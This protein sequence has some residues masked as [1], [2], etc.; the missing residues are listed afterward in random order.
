MP[1]NTVTA[2]V[3]IAPVVIKTLI[4]HSRKKGHKF[5]EEDETAEATDDILFDESFHIVKAFIELGTRNTVESL[6][7]FTNTHVPAPYWA[8]VVPVQIPLSTCNKAADH[9][10]EWFGP[11]DLK[12]VVGG[13]KWWQVRGLDGVD[14]EWITEKEYL[15]SESTLRGVDTNGTN[16]ELLRM[17]HLESVMLYVHGG[18][19]FWGS[20]NTHR[21]Q[22]IRY[23]QLHLHPYDEGQSL[24]SKLQYPWPC[25]VQ[26]V[27]AAYLYLIDPPAGAAHKPISPS[28]VVF[29]GDS[30]G[31]GLCLSVLTVI[32]DLGLPMPAGA[33]LIS[34]WVDLTHSF[35]SVMKNAETDIIP[36]YGF[37]HKPSTLWP[38]EP[39]PKD[40]RARVI[41]TQTNP[42]PY[43]GHAD[44]LRP[45]EDRLGDQVQERLHKSVE[46]DR[47]V[48][49]KELAEPADQVGSQEEMLKESK[50]KADSG[51]PQPSGMN[52]DDG[53][54]SGSNVPDEEVRTG[55]Q[56]EADANLA[57]DP[58]Y[59]AAIDFWE[60]K[61]PKVL[62][63][64][65]NEK[66]LE[67]RSQIQLYATNEQLTH[68]LVTPILQGSLGNL[69]PLYIIGGDG[70]VLRDEIIYLAHKAAHPKDY[71]TRKGV[72]RDG[73][74]QKEN[75]E[76]FQTP[77]KVHLQIFD[78]MCH[79]L[80]VF[81]FTESAK[82]AYRSIARFVKHV[83]QNSPEHLD[84]NPFPELHLSSSRSSSEPEDDEGPER[85]PRPPKTRSGTA[86]SKEESSAINGN[87]SAAIYRE[88]EKIAMQEVARGEADVAS[89]SSS[90]SE[91]KQ[92][93]HGIKDVPGVFMIRERVDVFGKVRPM[94][95]PGELEAL[96]QRPQD[97]GV[98][99]EAPVRRWL[100]GQ[101]LWD[102]KY[103]H[104]AR[105]V[106]LNRRRYEVKS[107]RLLQHAREEGFELHQDRTPSMP[108]QQST[109]SVSFAAVGAIQPERRW[110]P[111]DLEDEHP[112][113][114]AIAKRKDTREAYSLLK[115]S[116]Y[117][118]APKTHRMIPRLRAMD[119]IR[120]AE[121]KKAPPQSASEQQVETH[122]VPMHGLRIWQSL[123]TYF[124]RKSS[125]KAADGKKGAVSAVRA[126]SHKLRHGLSRQASGDAENANNPD[127]GN[128]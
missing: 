103:K 35:P 30:A 123:I 117:H 67:L 42:P 3:H 51:H 52:G 77:T 80:T 127:G 89:S 6:Q 63:R 116:I 72:L 36:P 24:R 92:A 8:S 87:K 56:P 110:G 43:P 22:V 59:D 107:A 5:Y 9:L 40:G 85:P 100:T 104:A 121:L 29:A 12:A 11:E 83:T 126:S 78:G 86:H 119:A 49:T 112:P 10:I 60:P 58:N 79:V 124:M 4:K 23:G 38:I 113:A 125:K 15:A 95:S 46:E 118:T 108:R 14:A 19:Y 66:P 31:A 90:D 70:E 25:P 111:L 120:D 1:V 109:A 50:K 93:A 54:R 32:R 97:I 37:I 53:D 84:R 101:E 74:R 20:I 114:S 81:T 115:K 34:P 48:H 7:G 61:P 64:D 71:P 98:I 27:I 122:M 96:R 18:A 76:K 44:T 91:D 106:Y 57:D 65:P 41:P 2:A 88:N 102:D 94:E 73:R 33:V 21:Y 16:K 39:L 17:E 45:S 55:A 28:K 26:D 69:C 128:N 99:K 105:R 62:M 47:E 75:V 13:E 68:P 82:Y